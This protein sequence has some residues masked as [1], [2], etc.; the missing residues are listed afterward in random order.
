MKEY[1]RSTTDPQKAAAKA[2][3]SSAPAMSP[4]TFSFSQQKVVLTSVQFV[5]CLGILPN[6]QPGVGVPLEQRSGFADVVQPK[7]EYRTIEQDMKLIY[8]VKVL[9]EC[10]KQ[11][12]LCSLILARHFTDLLAALCQINF[13]PGQHRRDRKKEGLSSPKKVG[14]LIEPNLGARVQAAEDCVKSVMLGADDEERLYC[15]AQLQML[16]DRVYQPLVV[17]E[18]LLLQGGGGPGPGQNQLRP[19][20]SGGNLGAGT[21]RKGLG[22]APVWLRKACGRLLSGRLMKPEGVKNILEGMLQDTEGLYTKT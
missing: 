19:P 15:K 22:R 13:A 11:P 4:D 21:Q 8:S 5:V 7:S 16:L 2:Q 6:L 14:P 18:L 20:G 3:D 17:R 1:L 10:L 9:L 12:S